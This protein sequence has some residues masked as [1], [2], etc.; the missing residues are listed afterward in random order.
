MVIWFTFYN[1]AYKLKLLKMAQLPKYVEVKSKSNFGNLNG[2]RLQVV[3]VVGT[4]ITVL[5]ECEHQATF[6]NVD[7]SIKE[8]VSFYNEKL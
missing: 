7:F 5:A 1:L 4:R 6:Q 3:E 2:K 8:I